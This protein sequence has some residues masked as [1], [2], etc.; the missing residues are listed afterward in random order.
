MVLIKASW[1]FIPAWF[2]FVVLM[3]DTIIPIIGCYGLWPKY[4]QRISS[5]FPSFL[6]PT[7][8]HTYSFYTF[9]DKPTIK[10]FFLQFFLW[11]IFIWQEVDEILLI[12]NFRNRRR[13]ISI[14]IYLISGLFSIIIKIIVNVFLFFLRYWMKTINRLY[15]SSFISLWSSSSI[16]PWSCSD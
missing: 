11:I 1:T 6:L 4:N 13:S 10:T 15:I 9:C 5:V 7:L 2:H 16:P 12:I 3:T 14:N 8:S